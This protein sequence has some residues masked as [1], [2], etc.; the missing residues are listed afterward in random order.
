MALS[1]ASVE[2]CVVRGNVNCMMRELIA[3][4]VLNI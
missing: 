4:S 1:M 3:F 2:E